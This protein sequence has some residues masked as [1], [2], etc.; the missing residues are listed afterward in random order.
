M[1]D[2][3]NVESCGW[4][5]FFY[6]VVKALKIIRNK[7]VVRRVF[8]ALCA[9]EAWSLWDYKQNIGSLFPT[10]SKV[11]L[12]EV[13]VVQT[14]TL[15]M[16][17]QKFYYKR[18]IIMW[19]TQQGWSKLFIHYFS[20]LESIFL[21]GCWLKEWLEACAIALLA[22]TTTL[23]GESTLWCLNFDRSKSFFEV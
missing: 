18:K 1:F 12:L 22:S 14:S 3:I 16:M 15:L 20:L 11:I 17:Y 4:S 23:V 8:R 19:S 9:F 13:T 7:E 6:I 5:L 21:E 2:A 10:H